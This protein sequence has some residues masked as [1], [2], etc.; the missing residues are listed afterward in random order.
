[1]QL[2][3]TY[4]WIVLNDRI[5]Q[6]PYPNFCWDKTPKRSKLHV[7]PLLILLLIIASIPFNLCHFIFTGIRHLK[8]QNRRSWIEGNAS[9]AHTHVPTPE[10]LKYG[11]KIYHIFLSHFCDTVPLSR[12]FNWLLKLLSKY[13]HAWMLH[14]RLQG[15]FAAASSSNS[16]CK[17]Y[18]K[19]NFKL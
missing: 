12:N 3:K 4:V 7:Q 5:P 19:F 16:P 18:F 11:M 1:M 10:N 15:T 17:F 6:T 9:F 13:W 2:N 8:M 14:Q